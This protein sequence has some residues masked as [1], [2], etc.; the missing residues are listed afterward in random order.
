M[1]LR[2]GVA[3]IIIAG[4]LHNAGALY[5]T[6]LLHPTRSAIRAKAAGGS[7]TSG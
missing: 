7:S 1:V 6:M 4:A 2:F 3:I 5:W